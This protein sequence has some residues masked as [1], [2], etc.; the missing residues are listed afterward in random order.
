[1][2]TTP[3]GIPVVAATPG[4]EAALELLG[5][6]NG[7]DIAEV[8]VVR[9]AILERTKAAKKL[10]FRDAEKRDLG[11]ALGAGQHREQAQEQDF[12]ERVGDFTLLAGILE[13]FEMTQKNHRFRESHTVDNRVVHHHSPSCES[14]IGIDSAL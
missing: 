2:A 8:T 11:K 7:Q 12:I 9:R 6:E 13:V 4:G 3:S 1:M 10:A 5:V 14:R